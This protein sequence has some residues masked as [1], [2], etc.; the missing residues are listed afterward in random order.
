MISDAMRW[1]NEL[2]PMD[3]IFCSENG[4]IYIYIYFGDWVTVLNDV[5]ILFIIHNNILIHIKYTLGYI[6]ILFTVEK[7]VSKEYQI[8]NPIIF[9]R[10]HQQIIYLMEISNNNIS[11]SAECSQCYANKDYTFPFTD[12]KNRVKMFEIFSALFMETTKVPLINE[13]FSFYA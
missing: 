10:K 13:I 4:Q 5:G 3:P 2:I 1:S 12:S 7:Y 8:I 6:F 9:W 11:K